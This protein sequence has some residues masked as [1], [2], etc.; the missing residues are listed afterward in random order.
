MRLNQIQKILLLIGLIVLLAF[1]FFALMQRAV[2]A[3]SIPPLDQGTLETKAIAEAQTAGLQ[4]TPTAKKAVQMTLAE[5]LTLN[6]A[7][8]GKDAAQFGLTPDMPVF[9]LAIQGNVESRMAGLPRP[10]QT[11]PEHY[12]NITVVLNARTGELVW[13][14]TTRAGFSMPVPV[15]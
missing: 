15:P 8:L 5:W 11:G 2:N 6:D 9:V 7:E 10:G 4:G 12:D 1:S 13:I 3:S 14:G